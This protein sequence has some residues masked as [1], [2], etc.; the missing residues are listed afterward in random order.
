M[1]ASGRAQLQQKGDLAMPM[2]GSRQK[3]LQGGGGEVLSAGCS[4]DKDP[5]QGHGLGSHKMLHIVQER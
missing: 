2:S 5:C 4:P 3:G 1:D